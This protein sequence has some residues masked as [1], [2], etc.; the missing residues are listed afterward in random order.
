MTLLRNG[1]NAAN[2]LLTC[3]PNS[4]LGRMCT[5]VYHASY[6]MI[7]FLCHLCRTRLSVGDELAGQYVRCPSCRT[8]TP[9][10][11]PSA[12]P[13]PSPSFI[14]VP[15]TGRR[16]GF[17]CPFCSSRLEATTAT[18]GQEGACPT[19][20]STITI[21]LMDRSGRLLDPKTREIL[22]P[23][24][25]PVHA[26]AAAGD[27]APAIIRDESGVQHIRCP[28]CGTQSAMAANTCRSCA[29]P[30]TM[31]GAQGAA[32][33]GAT[34]SNMAVASLVL[35]IISLPA[36]LLIVPAALAIVFGAIAIIQA[37]R[38][39]GSGRMGLAISG[40]VCGSVSLLIGVLIFLR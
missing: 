18:S 32:A 5:L 14:G 23:D 12:G 22:K 20:G 21:P 30:F 15:G 31:E 6:A 26:Y 33:N 13:A 35:G 9:A 38:A 19:C 25:H 7:T 39:E 37:R 1:S 17:P 34:R 2:P 29:I 4:T 8:A 10:P 28:R 16:F 24:P 36:L 3:R 11:T 40:I 27:R